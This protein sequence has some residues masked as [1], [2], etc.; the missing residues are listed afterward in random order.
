MSEK[1]QNPGMLT[2]DDITEG[3]R[4]EFLDET[5]DSL[6]AIIIGL[7]LVR[8]GQKDGGEMI[9]ETKRLALLL[10]GQ[11]SNVGVRLINT[12]A[13]R[14]A[15]YLSNITELNERNTEDLLRFIDAMSEVAEGVTPLDAD[16][17]LMVRGLPVKK[18]FDISD[19]EIRNVEVMLVMASGAAT[20]F[21]EREMR[22]CGY[23][24]ISVASPFEAIPMIIRTKPD[25]VVISA[26]LS[27]LSGIDLAIALASMP[28]T[29][30][31]PVALITSFPRDHESL[32][33]LPDNVPVIQKGPNF[34][35]D[36]VEALDNAF[37][38]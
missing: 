11:A 16:P 27:E 3:L 17:S 18:D 29:R 37:L 22:Q 34:G 28:A 15:D 13:H 25:M 30:N 19:I 4:T 20:H 12:L 10:K 36:L 23:R 14:L 1:D 31:M 9:A 38:L 24:A 33:L 2:L 6:R 8:Q 5:A 26:V 21:V 7:D 35:E 32:K